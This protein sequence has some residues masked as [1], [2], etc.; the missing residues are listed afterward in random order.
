VVTEENDS[1]LTLEIPYFRTDVEVEDDLIS[2][3]LRIHN[4]TSIP[5]IALSTPVPRDITPPIYR[6]EDRLRDLMKRKD[7][8]HTLPAR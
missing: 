8:R 3:I 2:D 7:F 4:Y 1:E 6:F 5:Q